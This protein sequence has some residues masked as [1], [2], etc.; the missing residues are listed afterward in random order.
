MK[1]IRNRILCH[2]CVLGMTL[3]MA[4]LPTVV[5]ATANACAIEEAIR[6]A[7]SGPDLRD[8]QILE[9]IDTKRIAPQCSTESKVR[10]VEL[11]VFGGEERGWIS[12]ISVSDLADALKH[13]IRN[14]GDRSAIQ[15]KMDDRY[16]TESAGSS[17][18]VWEAWQEVEAWWNDV[19]TVALETPGNDGSRRQEGPWSTRITR[20][21]SVTIDWEAYNARRYKIDEGTFTVRGDDICQK[22]TIPED[23]SEG[24]WLRIRSGGTALPCTVDLSFWYG[25]EEIKTNFGEIV[26]QEKAVLEAVIQPD[27]ELFT[28]VGDA[29]AFHDSSRVSVQSVDRDWIVNGI[30][31]DEEDGRFHWTADSPGTTSV[32]LALAPTSPGAG[33]TLPADTAA[34][35]VHV[36]PRPKPDGPWYPDDPGKPV[37]RAPAEV[38]VRLKNGDVDRDEGVEIR[39]EWFTEPVNLDEWTRQGDRKAKPD[40]PADQI[41]LTDSGV[42]F[43]RI[44]YELPN[45]GDDSIDD[46]HVE[47]SPDRH[48]FRV[49]EPASWNLT[50]ASGAVAIAGGVSALWFHTRANG[51]FDDH[52]DFAEASQAEESSRA[53][54][55]YL[56]DISRRDVSWG[57]VWTGVTAAVVTWYLKVRRPQARNRLIDDVWKDKLSSQSPR[58]EVQP[59][60]DGVRLGL[61]LVY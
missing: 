7:R 36:L 55:D 24:A 28:I 57:V 46:P 26:V 4:L 14:E 59:A 60:S 17:S 19:T 18:D 34:V 1:H 48:W 52:V 56:A 41:R 29:V 12:E 22:S 49:H 6:A 13:I 47:R 20:G 23:G 42:Y 44:D 51:H 50:W 9:T 38:T 39:Y 45:G 43:L 10:F 35:L 58:F 61:S 53:W 54:D 33:A 11:L 27:G 5:P 32:E 2:V 25:D 37:F 31:E 3:G 21:Q 15:S 40:T 30:Q 8:K 16:Q